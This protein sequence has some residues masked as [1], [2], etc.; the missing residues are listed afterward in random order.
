MATILV[1]AGL[2]D[3]LVVMFA[4]HPLPWAVL[5]PALIPLLTATFVIVPIINAPKP[6][7]PQTTR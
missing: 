1:V 5:I 6:K 4:S 3:A 2:T 7:S